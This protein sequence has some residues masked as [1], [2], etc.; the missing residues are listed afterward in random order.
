MARILVLCSR[1]P[2]PLTGG[3]KIRMFYT[4]RELALEHDVELL[5]VDE[6]P[7]DDKA[8]SELESVF[9]DVNVFSHP[10]SRFYLNTVPGLFSRRPLQAH[11]FHFGAVNT[12]LDEHEHRFDLLYCNHVRTTEYVRGR[13]TPKVVD[14]VDAI[15]RNYREASRDA[16]GLW[17]FIYPLEY[18]RLRRYE[19]RVVRAFDRA[20]I[21]TT[22]DRAFITDG[23]S[24]PSPSVLPNGVKPELL[25]REPAAHRVV[26]SA[27]TIVFLGK[28]DY[29]PN[30]NAAEYFASEVFPQ[31]R[32]TYPA[33]EFFVVGSSPSDKV[34]VLDDIPGVT[35][36]GF[37]EDPREYLNRADV[38][39]A[40]MRHGAGL[41][42]KVLEAMALGRPIV[43]TSLAREGINADDGRHL[44]V[45][46]DPQ[47]FAA[48][49]TA[50]LS[51]V[52]RRRQIGRAAR[53][54]VASQYTWERIGKYL[55]KTV[56]ET[57]E[58]SRE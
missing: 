50:L 11:Y 31:V 39:V 38:V 6:A 52:E 16:S 19:R 25:E 5:V 54:L 12:W 21:I 10:S 32:E 58:A 7:V 34:A 23:G 33:A 24:Y 17:R 42:N 1:L 49:A 36:T 9:A 4:A 18:R 30:E 22:A 56:G 40:P 55:R 46:D 37:V 28:M 8:I 43:V 48:E 53:D 57:L 29:F 3:A 27:P 44:V 35:V 20:F 51:N 13:S 47:S 2:Y 15:S 41:Q 26:E 45:A 14:L